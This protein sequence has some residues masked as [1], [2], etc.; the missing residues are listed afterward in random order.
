M[1]ILIENRIYIINEK[2]FDFSYNIKKKHKDKGRKSL[3][4]TYPLK[5]D[6]LE[7][8][9]K[10]IPRKLKKKDKKTIRFIWKKK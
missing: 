9:Q 2:H 8:Y 3:T 4:F 6:K 5:F 1:P 7:I 10:R